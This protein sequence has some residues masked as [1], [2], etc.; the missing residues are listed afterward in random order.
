MSL[1]N[2]EYGLSTSQIRVAVLARRF[3]LGDAQPNC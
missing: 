1:V 2:S 3:E